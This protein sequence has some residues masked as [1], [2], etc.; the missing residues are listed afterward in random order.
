[1]R[2]LLATFVLSLVLFYLAYN[3]LAGD[4]GL[5]KWTNLQKREKELILELE[6]IQGEKDV[7]YE[8][9][10][11]LRPETLDLDY[12]EEIARKKLAYARE[13]EVILNVKE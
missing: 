6:V 13:D 1:M 11:R 7:V 2:S 10:H 9:I 12:I 8:K 5:A 3:A 4:Q